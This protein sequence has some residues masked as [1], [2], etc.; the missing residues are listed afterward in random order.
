MLR[1]P[2]HVIEAFQQFAQSIM[3]WQFRHGMTRRCKRQTCGCGFLAAVSRPE[4][5][6]G[7]SEK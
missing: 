3:I 4:R 1:F 7:P 5:R 6:D 2:L